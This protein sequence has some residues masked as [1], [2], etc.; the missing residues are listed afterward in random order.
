MVGASVDSLRFGSAAVLLLVCFRFVFPACLM[1]DTCIT[2]TVRA[3]MVA[4]VTELYKLVGPKKLG[5]RLVPFLL[6]V[7]L[8]P[9]CLLFRLRANELCVVLVIFSRSCKIFVPA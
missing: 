1:M 3:M 6:C 9:A 8:R 2:G 5:V 7:G 4:V